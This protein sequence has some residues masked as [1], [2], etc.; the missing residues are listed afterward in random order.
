MVPVTDTA[1]DLLVLQLVLHASDFSLL[2]LSIF[3]P[4]RTRSEYDIFS[5]GGGV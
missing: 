5:D 4:V 1:L 2:L 3:A